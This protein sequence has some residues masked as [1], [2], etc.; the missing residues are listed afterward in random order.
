MA[1]RSGKRAT[2]SWSRS[3]TVPDR[4]CVPSSIVASPDFP[5]A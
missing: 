4:I 1:G 3:P 5:V 2:A